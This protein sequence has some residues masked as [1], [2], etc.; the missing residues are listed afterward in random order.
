MEALKEKKRTYSEKESVTLTSSRPLFGKKDLRGTL[1]SQSTTLRVM[2]AHF[3]YR[4]GF[5]SIAWQERGSL[6]KGGVR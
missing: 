3:S 5:F 1:S 2:R 4:L 6:G